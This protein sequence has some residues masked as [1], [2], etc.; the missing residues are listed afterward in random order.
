MSASD[1]E[2]EGPPELVEVPSDSNKVIP[3]SILAGFLGSGKTTLLNHILT[4][5]H[6]KR[7][8]VIEN[9]FGEGLGIESMIA[10]S[11]VDGESISD[12]F[13][14]SNGCICCTVKD[15]LVTTL[16][17]LVAH[18]DRFDYILIE[19]TGLANPGPVVAALWTDDTL[20]NR[21]RLDGVV[22]VVDSLNIP[23][24]L[25]QDDISD[26]V[27]T[28]ICYAD[29]ILLNKADLV[30]AEQMSSV[31]DMVQ[32]VNS[33][34]QMQT[35][36]FSKVNLDFVLNTHSYETDIQDNNGGNTMAAGPDGEGEVSSFVS[37][38]PCEPTT[39]AAAASGIGSGGNIGVNS[40]RAAQKNALR[41]LTT[42]AA[43]SVPSVPHIPTA[44]RTQ[45]LKIPGRFRLKKLQAALDRMLY[46][47][48]APTHG[49]P[50]AEKSS[51]LND[52]NANSTEMA[53]FRMKGLVHMEGEEKLF[54]LQA[55]HTI[56][57]V[58]PSLCDRGG[59]EDTTDGLSVFVV[60]GKYL[61]MEFVEAQLRGCLVDQSYS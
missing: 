52:A 10:K 19:T 22:C 18:R 7:I 57:D 61:D 16:E 44:M 54:I 1:S 32:T 28:Q 31:Q 38:V 37:C 35:S 34:A 11:G 8:A 55:V 23:K 59:E 43:A 15:N 29:R 24:Y 17:Q 40:S 42:A 12:F 56:F 2:D 3:V 45:Y 49:L 5:N 9:E 58:Q 14:L 48:S 13:E 21:L 4:Q 39:S 36:T 30:T 53:I 6:G 25:S 46:T 33:H 60:I 26:D 20:D 41:A 47:G 27:K 51:D 50:K